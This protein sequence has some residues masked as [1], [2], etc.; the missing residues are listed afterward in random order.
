M[1]RS[2]GRSASASTRPPEA[3]RGRTGHRHRRAQRLGQGHRGATGRGPARLAA[4]RQRGAL[5]ARG[6][7][8]ARPAGSPTATRPGFAAVATDL[9]ARFE[10]DAHGHERVLLD[11]RDVTLELRTE[12]RRSRGLPG[13]GDAPG[14]RGPAR[15][16]AG[17]RRAA[18]AG[19]RRP[20]HGHGGFPGAPLKVYLTASAEERALRR[21]KQLKE[22]GLTA[23]LAALSQEILE[24]GS[25]RFQ[26]A[27]GATAPRAGRVHPRLDRHAGGGGGGQGSRPRQK[28]DRCDPLILSLART[29][30]GVLSST[31]AG[32]RLVGIRVARPLEENR[33]D[34]EFCPTVRREPGE[35]ANSPG[36]DPHRPRDRNRSRQGRGE[37]RPQVR[38]RDRHPAVQERAWRDRSQ[39][40]RRR[41]GRP[42][43]RR[44][45]LRRDAPVARKSQARP[46]LGAPRD[47]VREGRG[48][49][50]PHQ[51]PRQGRLHRRDRFRARLPAGLAR[52]RAPGAR[53]ELPRG[54]DARVQGHQARP[55]AQQRRG[56]APRRR[57]AG[58]Q[59]R[60]QRTARQAAGRRGRQGRGQEPHRLRRVRRPRRHRRPAAHHRHG[61][62][63]RQA[64]VGSR[65]RR[66]RDRRAHPQVRPRAPARQPGPQAARRRSVAEHRAPLSGD[67][68]PVR[69]GHEHRRLRLL[70]GDRGGRRGPGARLRDGLDEQERQSVEGRPHRRGSRGHGAR[71][72]RG[73]PPHLARHQAVQAESV[74]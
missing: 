20:G 18:R 59:R 61:V 60:A 56:L 63:A 34:R 37:R 49:H 52:G 51:R 26:P 7:G 58:V 17:V 73:A 25:A 55:E 1:R 22:K 71:H 42:R 32:M 70:R 31:P 19:R 33:N 11:G 9:D 13:R 62:E 68:A 6:D 65:Q 44:G 12:S 23:N 16:P 54:Q 41:R 29:D 15:P 36:P 2:P 14:P 46:H 69:Q 40:R 47:G 3:R 43:Q 45:R 74:A 35:P 5:P 4:A 66:R 48:R 50:G 67:H 24:Q 30:A 38:G 57:R 21:H 64:P 10:V 53:P 39:G 72:R 8:R 28:P 27:R